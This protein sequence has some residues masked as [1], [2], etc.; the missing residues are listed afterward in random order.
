MRSSLA[1]RS[2]MKRTR[3]ADL[4]ASAPT[5]G[6]PR[7]KGEEAR[8]TTVFVPVPAAW[9]QSTA[10][11]DYSCVVHPEAVR[12][13][14][15]PLAPGST[16]AVA[17]LHDAVNGGGPRSRRL[18]A[19]AD[20]AIRRGFE[21]DLDDIGG[22]FTDC[23][24]GECR[25]KTLPTLYRIIRVIADSKDLA[26][27]LTLILE[28]MEQRQRI[29]RGMVTLFDQH[30]GRIF[31]HESFGLSEEE[32]ARGIYSLGEGIIGAVVE[33]GKA[34]VAPRLRDS[35]MFLNRTGSRTGDDELDC[36]FLCLPILNG[37]RVLGTICAERVY[38][39]N[40]LLRQD[41]EFLAIVASMI[42]PAVELYLVENIERKDLENE[43]RRLHD[44]LKQKFKPSN[45]I[46]NSKPMQDVYQLIGKIAPA[47]TSVLILG[48]SGVGKELVANAIH[49]N[50]PFADGPFVKFNCAAL[51]ETIVESE[52]FGHEKGSFTGATG[53]RKGRFE[54]AD[55]GTVFLD[56]VGELPLS[57]QAKLLR[58]L[59]ERTFERIGGTRAVKVE[60]RI[61]AATNRDLEAMVADGTFREDLFYRLNV[62]P[63]TIPPLR[64]RGSDVITLADH[65]VARFA[66]ESGK[67]VKRISTPALDMLMSYHWP[68]NV[69]E[70]ENVIERSVI[71]S[72]DGVIHGYHLPPS[73]Q[74]SVESGTS[75]GCGLEAKLRAVEYEMIVEALKIHKGN[76]TEAAR[77][78]NLTR[79]VLGLRM[80][81][82]NLDYRT[83]RKE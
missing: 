59:Q 18:D 71:L 69:R 79:R 48:E 31:I 33:S 72:D 82:Y 10:S 12:S 37:G 83:F 14:R 11:P 58:V 9:S 21:V 13:R 7:Q 74:T 65:F 51:P 53:Q 63:I 22:E 3:D 30:A 45:I 17:D 27:A 5:T 44:A 57:V 2:H 43:N 42:A 8:R 67:D 40:R 35:S 26:D 68:G 64:D 23:Q 76:T 34:I 61:I 28:V 16:R 47:K 77:E 62:F 50:S 78:L 15:A 19:A 55:K 70:L 41:F 73:L 29:V 36:S 32:K 66:A 49:Y 56:E 54:L 1:G 6:A 24:T 46:G 75:F 60:L 20:D 81:Q 25:I 52:L 39:N 38:E 4:V 80:V